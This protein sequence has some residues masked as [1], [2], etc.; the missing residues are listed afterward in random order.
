MNR[1][2][3][4]LQLIIPNLDAASNARVWGRTTFRPQPWPV[5]DPSISAPKFIALRQDKNAGDVR[6]E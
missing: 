2:V 6:R 1:A 5:P 4:S 3:R